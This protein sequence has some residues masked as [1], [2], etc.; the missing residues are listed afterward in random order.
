MKAVAIVT[1]AAAVRLVFA[2]LIP[3]FPD[4]TYYWEWSRRL[5][6]GYFDHPAAI[7]LLI[8]LGH[9][10]LA[11]FHA[12]ATPLAVRLAVIV[13]GWIAALV[14]VAIARRLRGDAAAIRAAI[15]VSV[16]PLAAAGLIL[17]T[18]DVP[19]LM[20]TAVCLYCGT[21]VL[22]QPPRSA[23]SLLWWL[24][25]GAAVGLA[26][27]SKYT[28][29]FL[30]VG[31]V[32]AFI[33]RPSLRDRLAEPGPYIACVIASIVFLPVLVWNRDHGW[34][35]FVFQVRHGLAAPQGS[36]LVA[37][38]KHEGDF[39]GGQ[40][41]LA[42]PILFVM[43]GIA[44]IGAVLGHRGEQAIRSSQDDSRFVL[45]VVA[46]ASFGF[47]VYSAVRQRV[48]PNWP[49]PAYIPAIVLLAVEDWSFTARKWFRAG[50]V[51]AGVM[52]ALIY[53]QAIRPVLPVQ[54][55]KDPIGRA[56]GWRELTVSTDS[57]ADAIHRETNA[58]TWL[59][60]DRYQEASE[61]AFH[62]PSH[63]TTFS[64]NI[65]GRVNQY[66]LWPGFPDVARQGDNLVLALDDSDQ[67]HEA[68][69]ALTPYF[70]EV[71]R[72]A[73]VPLRR[74]REQISTRRLWILVAWRGGWPSATR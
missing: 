70:R 16:M 36:A 1:V 31:V 68:V 17:A 65:S 6:P 74:G 2:A 32:G 63:N 43:M 60:G 25:T 34:I 9:L 21:R 69:K 46:V 59:G 52:S 49:S 67:P 61:L 73:L 19:V 24:V 23:G 13:A 64:T 11:P 29:I 22:E 44:V 58:P 51:L 54:P 8:R 35:S 20:M 72:G 56:F 5:A 15:V 10:A 39:W 33:A 57:T 30:P 48:E 45:G 41:A 14:T 50:I 28:S 18:P 7:A 66:D 4:E 62:D 42:S 47:F 71:R 38:W 12:G 26:F 55:R 53:V 3:V 37:A 27:S 40:A